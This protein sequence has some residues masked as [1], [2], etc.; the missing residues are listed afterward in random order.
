MKN[1]IKENL[2]KK[3][4]KKV[5]KIKNIVIDNKVI[6]KTKANYHKAINLSD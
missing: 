5:V 1:S 2:N 4:N 6:K 3:N